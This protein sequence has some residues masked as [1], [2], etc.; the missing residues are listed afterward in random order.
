MSIRSL[1]NLTAPAARLSL[2][3]RSSQFISKTNNVSLRASLNAFQTRKY[4]DGKL[5]TIQVPHLADSITEGTFKTWQKEI[6]E[7]VSL[8]E[9]IGS[10]ETDKVD[11]P[12]N[13][14]VAG[15][16]KAHLV[17]ND[18]NVV[19]GQDL[20]SIDTEASA[21]SSPASPKNESAPAS[22]PVPESIKPAEMPKATPTP[23]LSPT[24]I[25]SQSSAPTSTSISS[26]N[27]NQTQSPTGTILLILSLL[28]LYLYHFSAS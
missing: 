10:I 23:Q 7:Y 2:I 28:Y 20:C 19:V 17:E 8:D 18:Q 22:I 15:V 24:S 25:P 6:G 21:D 14:P 13:S 11:I 26:N 4:A 27:A 5:F 9:E 1:I 12:I 16:M 3:P